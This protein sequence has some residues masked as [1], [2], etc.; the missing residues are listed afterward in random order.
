MYTHICIYIERYH[1]IM[2]LYIYAYMFIKHR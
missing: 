2:Y 1:I